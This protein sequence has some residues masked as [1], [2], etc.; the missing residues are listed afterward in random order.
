MHLLLQSYSAVYLEGLGWTPRVSGAMCWATVAAAE[1]KGAGASR[2][3][4]QHQR[5]P[6]AK[7]S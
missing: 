5:N 6:K 7:V 3:L 2:K 4:L 1:G